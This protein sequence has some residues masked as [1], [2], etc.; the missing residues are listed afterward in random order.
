MRGRTKFGEVLERDLH[1]IYLQTGNQALADDRRV[2]KTR[3]YKV[4]NRTDVLNVLNGYEG[5]NSILL[6]F[7]QH[8]RKLEGQTKSYAEWTRDAG[9]ESWQSWQGFYRHIEDELDVSTRRNLAWDYVPNRSGAFLGFWWWPSSK[10]EIYLQIEGGWKEAKLCFK[11]DAEGETNEGKNDLKWHW[12][13][14]VLAAG[15]QQVVKP[16]VMRRGNYMTVAWWKDHWM[17]FG[18]D[19]KLDIS[20]TI[21]NLKRA[22]SVVLDAA[23]SA[24]ASEKSSV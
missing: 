4:F 14:R 23:R 13:E 12:H 11:V 1:P 17:A 16:R 21:E 8:L 20:G 22:E 6:D 24:R 2:E 18:K 9:R 10:D 19:G 3:K 5:R 15:K 7:R